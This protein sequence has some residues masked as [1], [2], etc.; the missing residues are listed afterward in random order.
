MLIWFGFPRTVIAMLACQ[1]SN[2]KKL[3]LSSEPLKKKLFLSSET[4][5]KKLFQSSKNA[6]EERDASA[7]NDNV[8][9]AGAMREAGTIPNSK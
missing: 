2:K 8:R 9:E 5:K 7:K 4:R 1:H 6:Q 3:F